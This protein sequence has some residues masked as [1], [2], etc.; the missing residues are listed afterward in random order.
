ML[1]ASDIMLAFIA[2]CDNRF[3]SEGARADAVKFGAGRRGGKGS[4]I[5]QTLRAGEIVSAVAGEDILEMLFQAA[6][7]FEASLFG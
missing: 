6:R 7:A 4:A 2:S 1:V 3:E 5:Y